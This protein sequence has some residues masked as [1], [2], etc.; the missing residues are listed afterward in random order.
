[1]S[2]PLDNGK[3]VPPN[4]GDE[5]SCVEISDATNQLALN[6][7]P[8][9][10]LE[11]AALLWFSEGHSCTIHQTAHPYQNGWRFESNAAGDLD[12]CI[13]DIVV[14]NKDIVF[15]PDT[16]AR[17]SSYCGARGYFDGITFPLYSRTGPAP[18]NMGCELSISGDECEQ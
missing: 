3:C 6:P 15:K 10:N 7:L 16:G 11:F 4:E 13:L 5:N 17:C 18:D 2:A 9:G 14:E 8:D 12:K 1:M